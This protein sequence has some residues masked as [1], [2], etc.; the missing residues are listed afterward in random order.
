MSPQNFPNFT[1]F[2]FSYTIGL[3]PESHGVTANTI[4]DNKLH[5][6]IESDADKYMFKSNVTPIWTLNEMAGKHSTVLWPAGDLL[7]RNIST[8]H[9]VPSNVEIPWKRHIDENIIPMFLRKECTVNLAMF[10]L[11]QP[12]VALRAYSPQSKDVR[13][14][15]SLD[16]L[17]ENGEKYFFELF[18]GCKH[19][20]RL[21]QYG[22][23]FE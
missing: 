2:P 16:F 14:S 21:G 11:K 22:K 9:A 23:I 8:A 1:N 13:V 6:V 18:S 3:Y 10:N 7:Y 15:L 19:I 5:K 17:F 4:Y 12:K 20:E